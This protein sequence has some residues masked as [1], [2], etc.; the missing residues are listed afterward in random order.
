ML[1]APDAAGHLPLPLL[2]QYVAGALPAAEQHRVE[3]H[4]LDCPR[5]AEVL[6][7]LE[8]TDAASTDQALMELQQRLRQRVAQAEVPQ[9]AFRAWQAVAAVLLLLLAS[10]AVWWGLRRPAA[11]VAE[12]APVAMQLPKVA[13]NAATAP[14]TTPPEAETAPE[15][16]AVASAP[17]LTEPAAPAPVAP[18]PE[19]PRR[20]SRTARRAAAPAVASVPDSP[21]E[22]SGTMAAADQAPAVALQTAPA[23]AAAPEAATE[24]K[25]LVDT[26]GAP[27]GAIAKSKQILTEERVA[28]KSALP[29]VPTL[30][31]QPAGGYAR[32]REYL[33]REGMYRPELPVQQLSGTVR[34]KFTVTAAGKLENFQI[35]RSMRADYDAEAIRLL[36]EGPTWQPGTANGRRADQVVE[37]NI[38]F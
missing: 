5:C 28:R 33:R 10:T 12:S 26:V 4:T 7:G 16:P 35:V 31:P 3:A 34:V 18:R 2:R 14:V 24:S 8:L 17:V 9:R 19:L 22:V 20:A 27:A 11:P 1:P 38:S 13:D 36:C 30:S 29:P 21:A 32:L 23:N 37:I 25:A 6:E 15:A